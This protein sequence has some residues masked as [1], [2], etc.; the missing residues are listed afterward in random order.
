MQQIYL[1]TNVYI[2]LWEDRADNIRPLG[3]FAF[4]LFKKVYECK[5]TVVLSSFVIYELENNF[6][7]KFVDNM[8]QDLK[9]SGKCVNYE[10]SNEDIETAKLTAKQHN[11]PFSDTLHA[12]VAKKLSAS[13]LVTNNL[14]DFEKLGHLIKAISPADLL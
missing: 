2:D 9:K 10:V 7:A 5:Y 8:L 4:Q 13:E 12:V 14:K 6:P 3:E 1:D 11:S